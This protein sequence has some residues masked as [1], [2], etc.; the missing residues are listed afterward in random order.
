MSAVGLGTKCHCVGEG[1]QKFSSQSNKP[2]SSIVSS[3]CLAT[4]NEQIKDFVCAVIVV[5]SENVI[6][7][8]SYLL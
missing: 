5:I 2:C 8:F 1:E 7:I 3:R 4:T 6:V